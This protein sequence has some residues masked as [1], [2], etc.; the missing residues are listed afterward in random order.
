MSFET[1]CTLGHDLGRRMY[2]AHDESVGK[3][4]PVSFLEEISILK[5][6]VDLLTCFGVTDLGWLI[7]WNL[8]RTLRSDEENLFRMPS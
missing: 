2:D 4:H 1:D 7:A 3:K 6:V 8:R 5:F